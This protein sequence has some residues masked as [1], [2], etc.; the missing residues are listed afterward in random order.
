MPSVHLE[1][2]EACKFGECVSGSTV[3]AH[4]EDERPPAHVEGEATPLG[5]QQAGYHWQPPDPKTP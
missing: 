4:G 5:A 3:D 2:L 1:E